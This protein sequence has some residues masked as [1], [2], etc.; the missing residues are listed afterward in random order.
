[1]QHVN[2]CATV[3]NMPAYRKNYDSAVEMYQLGMS[4]QDVADAFGVRRQ[5]MWKILQRRGV[6]FRPQLRYAEDNHFH[7]GGVVKNA[8]FVVAKAVLRG[9]LIVGSCKECGL[10]PMVIRGRQRIH[11]HHNDYNHL[12]EVSWLCKFHHDEWHKH[13]KPI[14]R[15]PDWKPTPRR[16]I[17][18][19]GGRASRARIKP[20]MAKVRVVRRG[21]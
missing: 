17:A 7:R 8:S 2:H 5:A 13:N 3:K 6:E 11:G 19:M 1:L 4:I 10:P 12:L 20:D 16:E 14:P 15:S 21:K 9:I 18:E